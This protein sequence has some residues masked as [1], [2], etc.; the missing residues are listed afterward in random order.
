[1]GNMLQELYKDAPSTGVFLLV[2]HGHTDVAEFVAIFPKLFIEKTLGVVIIGGVTAQSVTVGDRVE[3]RLEP[4]M[5]ASNN[6]KDKGASTFLVQKCQEYCVRLLAIARD[7][8]SKF[9]MPRSVFDAML[10]AG[11][12]DSFG[13]RVADMQKKG[14]E[15]LWTHVHAV[16]DARHGLPE[17]CDVKWFE[18]TFCYGMAVSLSREKSPWEHVRA[19]NTYTSLALLVAVPRVC[20]AFFISEVERVRGINHHIIYLFRRSKTRASLK[21]SVSIL[22]GNATANSFPP[23]VRNAVHLILKGALMNASQFTTK[24]TVCVG[25]LETFSLSDEMPQWLDPLAEVNDPLFFT[26]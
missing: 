9:R 22:Q 12:E 26:V 25:G 5:E 4:D 20:D 24:A 1:M 7:V 6:S 14:V 8:T 2:V 18:E 16:G 19:F 11:G 21:R 17:R 13:R 10:E 15:E 23:I 3:R